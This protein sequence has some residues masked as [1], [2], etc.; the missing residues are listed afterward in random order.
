MKKEIDVNIQRSN[1]NALGVSF[2]GHKKE[3]DKTGYERHNFYYLYDSSK[4]KCEVELYNIEKDKKGNIF[5]V[6]QPDNAAKTIPMPDGG[7]T[8][9]MFDVP[10][11]NSEEGFAYR[12]KLTDR[13]NEKNVSYAFDNGIVTNIFD[14]KNPNNKFNVVFKNGAMINKN[15]PMQLI[16][17]DGYYPGIINVDG[18]PV[19]DKDIRNKA[20]ASV[21][22]HANKLGGNFYGIIERLP[23][24]KKEGISRIVGTPFT[25]DSISSHLY[26]TENA[27]QIAPD[28][29]TEEDFKTLQVELFKNGINWISDAALVN[30]GLQGI[31]ISEYLRKGNDSYSKN[32]FR[33]SDK[34]SLGILPNESEFTRMKVINAPFT[35]EG[36]TLKNNS[37]YNPSKPTYV[38]FY[39]DRLASDE[40]KASDSPERLYTYDNKNTDNIY[41]I[42]KHDDAVYP[43][44]IEVNPDELKRNVKDIL[45]DKEKKPLDLSKVSDLSIIKKLTDFSNFNIT[46]KSTAGGIEVWDGNVDIPKLNFYRAFADDPKFAK[47]P[48]EE[49]EQAVKDFE[50]G[51][52]AVQ[53]YAINSGR[54]WTKLTADTQLE[55]AS[56]T[57]SAGKEQSAAEYLTKIKELVKEGKLPEASL[58]IDEEIIQNVL[59]GNYNLKRLDDADMRDDINPDGYGN[60]YS[61]NDYIL[62]KSMDL[63]LETLPVSTNL[64][65]IL[66]SPY[67][68]KK[69]NT[70]EELG[71]SRY[72]L[73]KAGNPNLP[74]KYAKTYNK[75]DSLYE[76]KIVP[77]IKEVLG[78]VEGITA[79]DGSVTEYGK[80]VISEITPELTKLML[81]KAMMDKTS[82][83]FENNNGDFDF[84]KVN[85]ENITMQSLGIPY[86]GKTGEE[87]AEMLLEVLNK[88]IDN[89]LNDEVTISVFKEK[90]GKR[91]EGRNANDFKVAEM[92]AD[93]TESGLGWRID[94]TK[95]ITSMD[96]V[97]AGTDKMTECWLNVTDFWK[98]YNQTVLDVNPHAYTTAEITDLY[99]LFKP[100]NSDI[101]KSDGDAERKFLQ[102]TGIT[103]VAN[104]NYFF[105]LLPELYVHNSIEHGGNC[106]KAISVNSLDLRKKLDEGWSHEIENNPGF[107][108]QSPQNGVINSYT[109]IGNHDKPRILHGL[110]LNMGLYHHAF[111]RPEEIKKIEALK[112]KHP[113]SDYENRLLEELERD[114][115]CI[116]DFN[117]FY[118]LDDNKINRF[119][120]DLRAVAM[121]IRI[122]E[123]IEKCI[124]DK[125]TQT[126]LIKSLYDLTKGEF[127]GKKFDAEAFATRPFEIAIKS[128]F[129]QAEYKNDTK[130][131]NREEYE[132]KMLQNILE[133]AFDRF[134]SMYK[135]L[136][137]LPG[138]PTD[139]AGDRVGL[140]GY[141]TKTKNYHQQNRN[142]IHWE[143]L[144]NDSNNKYK[145]I[146][147]FYNKMNKI[148]NLRNKE[149]LSALNDGD[150]VTI[151][152]AKA[153]NEKSEDT[154]FTQ[155]WQAMLRYNDKGSVVLAIHH[156]SGA[157]AENTKMMK[158]QEEYMS[159][160][161][162]NKYY[163]II[164]NLDEAN[165]KQGLKH[166]LE[167]GTKFKNERPEDDSTYEIAKMN[168]DEKDYYYLKRT[169]KDGN[170][171]AISMKP[172]DLNTLILYKV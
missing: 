55:Y 44:A 130:I 110:A 158:R 166:G 138:S 25:K 117:N 170:E 42:T 162:S 36:T 46:T 88:G 51:T 14:D 90:I 82:E 95:D 87:E 116:E 12:F 167:V 83:I 123:A 63:P 58:E 28:F 169:N 120:A 113:R 98:K 65:E 7:T 22:N 172:E 2:S 64:L 150:T 141:E 105:S 38:Q 109:F 79:E 108:F 4:Y 57:I 84:S 15:G 30:E 17:P 140:T 119:D 146:R 18:K 37:K 85:R 53:D 143:W 101:F 92:L 86:S 16:M 137:A 160:D 153:P 76:N 125:T 77:F 124:P 50:R 145:F 69:A 111:I 60:D 67:L 6:E 19:L 100:E 35:V 121:G 52:L 81:V 40:Q 132:S 33:G 93:R 41:D 66:T 139:F 62:R 148:A 154:Y 49:R 72:D 97:R 156:T 155:Y 26:W 149:E 102:E 56:K 73:T 104:Y 24:L 136:I 144:N 59:D 31:H 47:L 20:L 126:T 91:F 78:N 27:Y 164:L 80:Y 13:N 115:A 128:V 71:V 70:E 1:F 129:D 68:A 112:Y 8:V 171:I 32:M 61:L 107:L 94:A 39:D 3:L 118:N 11:I 75:M 127:K 163:K 99:D 89:I 131:S 133:P 23:E 96:S 165:S 48:E 34:I 10:E 114:P 168:L 74:E 9:N 157:Q 135:L 54:Y 151:P 159:K 142:V 152:I 5:I 45:Q 161:K 106:K 103:S 134:Y 21:R 29:G 122:R 147:D 43:F